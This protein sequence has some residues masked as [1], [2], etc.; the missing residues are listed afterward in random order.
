MFKC[1]VV[2]FYEK[3]LTDEGFYMG[4]F[5]SVEDAEWE[6]E[7]EF[8]LDPEV[9]IVTYKIEDIANKEKYKNYWN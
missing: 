6:I 4:T 3:E 1:I 5:N 2:G 7:K 8:K 9:D